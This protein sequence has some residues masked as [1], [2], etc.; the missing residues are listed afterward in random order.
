[1]PWE[2]V[3]KFDL[4]MGIPLPPLRPKPFKLDATI[5]IKVDALQVREANSPGYF[6]LE[7]IRGGFDKVHIRDVKA[8]C[9]VVEG[10]GL[11]HF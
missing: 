11:L 8:N 4:P 2:V 1:M 6:G 9:I 7:K 10:V 3:T 5:H